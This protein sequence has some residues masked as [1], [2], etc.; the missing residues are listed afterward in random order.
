[1]NKYDIHHQL[2]EVPNIAR[3]HKTKRYKKDPMPNH[4]FLIIAV[5]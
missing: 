4:L 3:E 5:T 2:V 1:M